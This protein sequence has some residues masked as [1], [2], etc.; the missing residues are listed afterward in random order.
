MSVTTLH[1]KL[2]DLIRKVNTNKINT[3]EGVVIM[4]SIHCRLL[5]F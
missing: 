1:K 3:S 4:K 2:H 5:K